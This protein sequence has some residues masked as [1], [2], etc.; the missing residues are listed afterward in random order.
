MTDN[1]DNDKNE[2]QRFDEVSSP[3]ESISLLLWGA[4]K[5]GKTDFSGSTGSRSLYIDVGKSA[6]TFHAKDFVARRG[7]FKG[8]YRKVEEEA[9]KDNYVMPD[10][11]TAY[12]Q[13]CD[14]IDNALDKIPDQFDVVVVDEA[15]AFRRYAMNK[16]LEIN[17]GMNKSQANV[18]SKKWDMILPGIQDFG[19]EMSLVA[20]FIAGTIDLLKKHNKHF[21]LIAHER[22][23]FESVTDAKTG[24]KTETDIVKKLVP[25]FTGKKDIDAI[26]NMFDCVFHTEVA[27]SGDKT[28]Y[29]IRT[30]GDDGLVAGHRYSGVFQPVETNLTFPDMI[31]R[32]KAGV[33]K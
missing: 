8:F 15:T 12:D 25:A 32:I 18:A 1:E 21:I 9:S 5:T 27:R 6:E 13:V 10:K 33:G 11:A 28:I 17:A 31:R 3:A 24:K 20:Q 23:L 7:V 4:A 16:A 30:Q 26:A 19:S 14:I 22:A 29:R 2:F